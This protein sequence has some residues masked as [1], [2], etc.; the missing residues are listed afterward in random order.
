MQRSKWGSTNNLER[1]WRVIYSKFAKPVLLKT[2]L[3]N[4]FGDA[5]DVGGEVAGGLVSL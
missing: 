1:H 5:D 3:M 4:L 2:A